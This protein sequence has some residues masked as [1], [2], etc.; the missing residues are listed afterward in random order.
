MFMIKEITVFAQIYILK[1]TMIIITIIIIVLRNNLYSARKKGLS[2]ENQSE[3]Q[4][5]ARCAPS[6]QIE[7]CHLQRVLQ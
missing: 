4:W 2:N 3:P 7:Y 6:N 1:I 5:R